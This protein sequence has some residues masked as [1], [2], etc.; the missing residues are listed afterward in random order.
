MKTT[1]A[2]ARSTLLGIALVMVVAVWVL[3][4]L[5]LLVG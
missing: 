1:L 5:A 2:G 3:R 4:D